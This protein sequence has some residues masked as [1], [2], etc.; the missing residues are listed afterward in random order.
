MLYSLFI[1]VYLHMHSNTCMVLSSNLWSAGATEKDPSLDSR[2]PPVCVSLRC[3]QEQVRCWTGGCA[4]QIG[5]LFWTWLCVATS[6]RRNTTTVLQTALA[7]PPP[8]ALPPP[9]PP[10]FSRARLW[11]L[12]GPTAQSADCYSCRQVVEGL[13]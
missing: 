4:R 8:A 7:H 13:W 5:V 2:Q 3:A 6:C 11:G 9:E 1:C 10:F 12:H